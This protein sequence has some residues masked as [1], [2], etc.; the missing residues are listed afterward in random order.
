[1]YTRSCLPKCLPFQ[2]E[3]SKCLSVLTQQLDNKD[4]RTTPSRT[5][6]TSYS[7]ASAANFE[8]TINCSMRRIIS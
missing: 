4:T 1:M 5:V 8:Q 3:S 6:F 7:Y 2:Y